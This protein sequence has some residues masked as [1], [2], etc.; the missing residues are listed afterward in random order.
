MNLMKIPSCL[1][2]C[3]GDS[4]IVAIPHPTEE[5]HSKEQS[6]SEPTQTKPLGLKPKRQR[7]VEETLHS[8]VIVISPYGQLNA[9]FESR[10]PQFIDGG[11]TDIIS[12]A[13]TNTP[14]Y[15]DVIQRERTA[16]RPLWIIDFQRIIADQPSPKYLLDEQLRL[17]RGFFTDYLSEQ[18]SQELF[19]KSLQQ[20]T[21]DKKI[22]NILRILNS[23]LRTRLERELGAEL[24]NTWK[25]VAREHPVAGVAHFD[26]Y[27]SFAQVRKISYVIPSI[28]FSRELCRRHTYDESGNFQSN[29]VSIVDYVD[30]LNS[31]LEILTKRFPSQETELLQRKF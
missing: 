15:M 20:P 22:D 13:E 21:V 31:D 3:Q 24:E 26:L 28:E 11:Y 23:D 25:R 4:G 14:P 27:E 18:R 8:R 16:Q 1:K 17:V 7:T 30:K 2:D 5:V 6:L 19:E 10:I 12:E 9:Y 29:V